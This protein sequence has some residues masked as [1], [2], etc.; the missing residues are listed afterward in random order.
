MTQV[1]LVATQVV[2]RV[3]QGASLAESL[4]VPLTQF[5]D[6]RD[7]A[8]VQAICYGVCREHESLKQIL[9]CLLAKPL[10][11]KDQDVHALILV[12]LYQLRKMRIQAHAVIQETVS[13]A[14][15]LSKSWAKALVNALL[16]TYQRKK[17]AIEE[18]VKQLKNK[19]DH[20]PDWTSRIQEA[21][22]D[23]WQEILLANNLHPPFA[24]R[25]NEQHLSRD[26]YLKRLQI[27]GLNATAIPE[28][29]SGIILDK[30]QPVSLL[31]GFAAG[32]IFIQDGA[33]QLAAP[34]L[35]LAPSLRVLDACSAP[36]GKLTHILELAPSLAS[37][38]AV[39]KEQKRLTLLAE[40]LQRMH[41]RCQYICHDILDVPG[42]WDGN[43]FDRILV[44]APCSA[45]G[46][47]RRHPDIKLR[48]HPQE[49]TILAQTQLALLKKLF[50]LLNPGG[51]L[52]YVTC[53]IFPEEN[54]QVVEQFL[55]KEK[56]AYEE[57][58]NASWGL[59]CAVGRQ[60]LPGMHQMDGFYYACLRK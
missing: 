45:S 9:H 35:T 59:A 25:V 15:L 28:T 29:R 18:K 54:T 20:P 6:E 39:D 60:I 31:P 34:L 40:N 36:G 44:D 32:D 47:I 1:R 33:A 26:A 57:K 13:V 30:P 41:M 12:G 10:K 14:N 49:V 8:L 11:T 2:H 37:L 53:S 22:P 7:R 51:L 50:P 46:I 5:K 23:H 16:R 4:T 43:G 58:I 55:A 17:T 27:A 52:V 19:Y 48:R 56:M 24:L 38:I 3:M 42:W 21:W